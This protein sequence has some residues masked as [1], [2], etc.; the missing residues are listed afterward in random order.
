VLI[1][2]LVISVL[3]ATAM[4]SFLVLPTLVEEMSR[5]T[6]GKTDPGLGKRLTALSIEPLTGGGEPATLESL[7]GNVV[8][9]NFWGTWC[10]P[11]R[12]EFPHLVELSTEFADCPKFRLLLVSCGQGRDEQIEQLREETQAFLTD[13]NYQVRTYWDPDLKT[14]RAYHG[15]ASFGG[16]PTTFVLDRD[17]VI[18]GIWT[19]FNPNC[20]DE[21]RQLVRRL[22][23]EEDAAAKP[24][25]ES[26]TAP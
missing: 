26:A 22:V 21:I 3:I 8:V 25:D 20:V 1:P 10:P 15:A 17:G 13:S 12:R 24:G 9:V 19:G 2:V 11:C 23:N 7:A 6:P 5:P 14:R 18:R 16:Y 4:V